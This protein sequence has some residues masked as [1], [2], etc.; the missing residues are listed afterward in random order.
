MPDWLP[1]LVFQKLDW[2]SVSFANL[3]NL[4]VTQVLHTDYWLSPISCKNITVIRILQP[5]IADILVLLQKFFAP[6][7]KA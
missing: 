5:K 3:A 1:G 4:T 7:V 6:N 2:F